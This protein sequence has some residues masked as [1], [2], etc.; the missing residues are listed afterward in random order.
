MR[1]ILFLFL[2]STSAVAQD[3]VTIDSVSDLKKLKSVERLVWKTDRFPDP[4]DSERLLIFT[5]K[6]E[7]EIERLIAIER[8]KKD[9]KLKE[10]NF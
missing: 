4:E 9:G 7:R 1:I 10:G 6:V 2:I 8:K 5:E 3:V